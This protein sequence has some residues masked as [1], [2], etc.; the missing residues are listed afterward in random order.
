MSD[1][2]KKVSE[3]GTQSSMYKLNWVFARALVW[4]YQ[5]KNFY[6]A[7]GSGGEVL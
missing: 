3:S 7:R 6:F 1:K 4:D 5:L 2:L